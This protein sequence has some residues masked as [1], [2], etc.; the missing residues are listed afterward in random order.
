MASREASE[1]KEG[2]A[3]LL[4]YRGGTRPGKLLRGKQ[5]VPCSRP[6]Y[7]QPE[8]RSKLVADGEYFKRSKLVADGMRNCAKSLMI[9]LLRCAILQR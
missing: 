2:K 6:G 4:R 8:E 3:C 5:G 1:G 7:S 9:L